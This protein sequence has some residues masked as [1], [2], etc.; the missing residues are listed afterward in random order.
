MNSMMSVTLI[1]ILIFS[2]LS[3][4]TQLDI[5]LYPL[6][7]VLSY[8][9]S[10]YNDSLKWIISAPLIYGV[11]RVEIVFQSI[12]IDMA[13]LVIYEKSTQNQLF[14]CNACGNLLPPPLF[15]STSE[16]VIFISGYLSTANYF[17]SSSFSLQYVS[18]S[19]IEVKELNIVKLDL[20]MGTATIKPMLINDK[21]VVANS[22]QIWNISV[23]KNLLL[24]FSFSSLLFQYPCSTSL[25]I[26]DNFND[27]TSPIFSLNC[28]MLSNISYVTKKWFYSTTGSAYVLLQNDL[29][30]SFI[31]FELTYFSDLNLFQCGSIMYPRIMRDQSFILTDGSSSSSSIKRNMRCSW[32]IDPIAPLSNRTITVFVSRLSLRPGA[33]ISVYDGSTSSFNSLLWTS[34]DC[35]YPPPIISQSTSMLVTFYSADIVFDNFHGFQVEYQVNDNGS[36]GVGNQTSIIKSA[37]AF[38]I[39]PPGLSS[40]YIWYVQP[41]GLLSNN[42][43][44]VF[45]E[46]ELEDDDILTLYS[47]YDFSSGK[48]VA[49]WSGANSNVFNQLNWYLCSAPLIFEFI[50]S[51]KSLRTSRGFK[52]S[53]VGDGDNYKCGII[54]LD[55]SQKLEA[56]SMQLTDGSSSSHEVL[57][58]QY[59]R[60]VIHPKNVSS[61]VVFFNRLDLINGLLTLYN[62]SIDGDVIFNISQVTFG[63][64]PTPI[65]IKS[66]EVVLTYTTSDSSRGLGFSLT[67]YSKSDHIAEINRP[68][69]G[70]ISIM[71]SSTAQLDISLVTNVSWV[72]TPI[73]SIGSIYISFNRFHISSRIFGEVSLYDGITQ[74]SPLIHQISLADID[75][76]NVSSYLPVK[77]IKT[78]STKLLI[79]ISTNNTKANVN[80]LEVSYFSDGPNYHCYGSDRDEQ[81]YSAISMM[82]SDGSPSKLPMY[83]NQ[84]CQWLIQPKTSSTQSLIV[85][86]FLR[87]DMIGGVLEIYENKSSIPLWTC[88]GCNIVP[89]RLISSSGYFLIKF[90]TFN[91][92]DTYGLGFQLFYWLMD[93]ENY[94]SQ[95]HLMT[96]QHVQGYLLESNGVTDAGEFNT[97]VSENPTSLDL[98]SSFISHTLLHPNVSS[99]SIDGRSNSM[100]TDGLDTSLFYQSEIEH[101]GI[102]QT[103]PS[104]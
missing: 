17:Q 52:I 40:S 62:G 46:F 33:T 104:K 93:L 13:E 29:L 88:I 82:F 90:K 11:I 23:A 87:N 70:V 97:I 63:A 64:I 79:S 37:L 25:S 49:S 35:I 45:H 77:W 56:Y 43:L 103:A 71:S 4:S 94:T 34:S 69:D 50:P 66:D 18:Q 72:I 60:W 5:I 59:C 81:V 102:L 15:S 67:Y 8:T 39:H 99:N 31:D 41:D 61:L 42:L 89:R 30:H 75:D 7:G 96:N 84:I 10:H 16:V 51:S 28:S 78:T 86:E 47:G 73:S 9:L 19:S 27:L 14:Y 20:L 24:T 36:V 91:N 76:L 54:N 55:K 95:Y 32:L 98:S 44:V 6:K 65:S 53:Y 58:N 12:N 74:S 68:G 1:V 100:L 83:P 21:F 80:S 92:Q 2:I 101:C 3:P 48:V 85:L 26:F 38:D 57:S 22:S